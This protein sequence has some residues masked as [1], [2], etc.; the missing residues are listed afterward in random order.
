MNSM[1]E[2]HNREMEYLCT[3]R[4][5]PR[6][7]IDLVANR[8]PGETLSN[9]LNHRAFSRGAPSPVGAVSKDDSA[10][11]GCVLWISQWLPGERTSMATPKNG[12]NGSSANTPQYIGAPLPTNCPPSDAKSLEKQIVL[13]LVPT[14][15]ATAN[16][17]RSGAAT[18]NRKRPKGCDECQWHACS[19]YLSG[20]ETKQRLKDLTGFPNLRH[21]KFIAHLEVGADSGMA[22]PWPNDPNHISL[23]MFATFAPNGAVQKCEPLL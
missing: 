22:K 3:R 20:K 17:F 7:H 4:L 8:P 10:F 16:D 13:R 15:T 6:V 9:P 1:S 2:L 5:Y 18:P 14:G 12:A 23:W 11:E 19:V 21:M